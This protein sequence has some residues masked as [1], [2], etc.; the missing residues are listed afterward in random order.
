MEFP[1]GH[2]W[3][4]IRRNQNGEEAMPA[5]CEK[6]LFSPRPFFYAAL[7]LISFSAFPGKATSLSPGATFPNLAVR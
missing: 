3:P 4:V 7:L 1:T 5:N 2:F 6:M